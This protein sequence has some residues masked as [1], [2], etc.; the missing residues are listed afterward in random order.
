MGVRTQSKTLSRQ[1]Y[2]NRYLYRYFLWLYNIITCTISTTS[3]TPIPSSSPPSPH[4]PAIP[5]PFIPITT[6]PPMTHPSPQP[7]SKILPPLN[8]SRGS[9]RRSSQRRARPK[10]GGLPNSNMRK[11]MLNPMWLTNAFPT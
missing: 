2:R 10:V 9:S 6:S 5:A 3:S 4:Y 1:I 8:R 11:K 7:N